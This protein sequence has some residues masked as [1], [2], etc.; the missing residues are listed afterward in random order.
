VY[1]SEDFLQKYFRYR[2][3]EDP[4]KRTEGLIAERRDLFLKWAVGKAESKI[5]VEGRLGED[6]VLDFE[7][8]G[9]WAMKVEQGAISAKSVPHPEKRDTW[10]LENF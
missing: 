1:F 7:T 9:V 3:N 4:V 2:W 8:D 5:R 6:A 10:L